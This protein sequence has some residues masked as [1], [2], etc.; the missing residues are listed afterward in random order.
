MVGFL[1]NPKDRKI[2]LSNKFQNRYAD[3]VVKGIVA[4]LKTKKIKTPALF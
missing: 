2:I 1:S 3:A 4:Y